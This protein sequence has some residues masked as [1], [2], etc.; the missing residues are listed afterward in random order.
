[1][2]KACQVSE[3]CSVRLITATRYVSQKCMLCEQIE[4]KRRRTRKL[5][6]KIRRWNVEPEGLAKATK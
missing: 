5:D 2:S 1:C 6:D 3:T 4:L